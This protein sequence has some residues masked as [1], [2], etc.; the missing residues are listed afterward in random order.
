MR[1]ENTFKKGT[2]WKYLFPRS[3]F[4]INYHKSPLVSTFLL[5]FCVSNR[6]ENLKFHIF[7][8][9]IPS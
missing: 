7:Y 3:P 1:I 9:S 6:S 8:F 4:L 5:N 2:V